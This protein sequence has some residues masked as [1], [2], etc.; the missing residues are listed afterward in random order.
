M[1]NTTY[2]FFMDLDKREFVGYAKVISGVRPIIDIPD[3][4]T[5][6][7]TTSQPRAQEFYAFKV[8]WL[9]KCAY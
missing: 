8:E 3:L 6:L 1:A 2:L 4:Q 5:Y 9:S 7:G